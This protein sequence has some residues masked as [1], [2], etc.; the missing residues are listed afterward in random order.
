ML[1][2]IKEHRVVNCDR[3]L[4]S[5]RLKKIEPICVRLQGSSMK[6]LQDPINLTFG[7]QWHAKIGNKCII[8]VDNMLCP[9]WV[10][11]H[12]RNADH[13]ALVGDPACKAASKSHPNPLYRRR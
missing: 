7:N 9:F 11:S 12:I 6:D 8:A 13:M 5:E 3:H 1:E 10:C 2:I 4:S